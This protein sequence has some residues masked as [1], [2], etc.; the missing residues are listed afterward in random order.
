M[1]AD[2]IQPLQFLV[3]AEGQRTAVV[4]DVRAWELLSEWVET[5]TDSK[6]ALQSLTELQTAGGRPEQAGW[7]LWDQIRDAWDDEEDS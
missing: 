7:L 1:I 3:D 6:I 2:A 4:L 5:V